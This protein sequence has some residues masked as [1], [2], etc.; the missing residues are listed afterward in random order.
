MASFVSSGFFFLILGGVLLFVAQDRMATNHAGITFVL[1][2]LGVALLLYGTGTQGMG[3]FNSGAGAGYNIAIAGGAGIVAF[4]V[5]Y[6]I[7]KYSK[8]MRDA[9]QP[10]RKFVRVLV[11]G[12]DGVTDIAKYASTFEIDGVAV[13]AAIKARNVVEVY[14]PYLPYEILN[15]ATPVPGAQTEPLADDKGM[16]PTPENRAALRNL[17][18]R[19]TA[20]TISARFYRIEAGTNPDALLSRADSEFMVRLDQAIFRGNDGGIDYPAYPVRICVNLQQVE[21]AIAAAKRREIGDPASN[22]LK[23]NLPAA[24]IEAQ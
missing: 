5:A 16:C 18:Q 8:E 11:Q 17:D 21:L 15:P 12:G 9:F 10:E 19:A 3:Q 23:M 20:K 6:G 2:V 22:K 13:P 1:V 4:V 7:I 24:L 14:V